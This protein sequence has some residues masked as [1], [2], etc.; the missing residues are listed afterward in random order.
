M[1]HKTGAKRKAMYHQDVS[2][3]NWLR[4]DGQG[5]THLISTGKYKLA[6][7]LLGVQPRIPYHNILIAI[8]QC[9]PS[10]VSTAIRPV[11]TVASNLMDSWLWFALKAP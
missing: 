5:N 3:H 11:L 7:Q 6:V 8:M 10:P 2:P 4:L 1:G 9:I